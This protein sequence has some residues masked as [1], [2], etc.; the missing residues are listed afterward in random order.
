MEDYLRVKLVPFSLIFGLGSFEDRH[1]DD[2]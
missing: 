1:Q 2:N